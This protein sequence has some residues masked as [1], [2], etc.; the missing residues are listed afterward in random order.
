MKKLKIFIATILFAYVAIINAV[1]NPM[2]YQSYLYDCDAMKY[3]GE[4]YFSG[5][6]LA[7]DMLVS[8]DLRNWGWRTHVF[9]FNNTWHSGTDNDIH[10]SHIR[11]ENGIFHYYA[12]L[13]VSAG[14]R[15][16][17]ATNNISPLAPYIEHIKTGGIAEWIDSDTFK[18]DDG[19][20]YFYSTRLV[21]GESIYSR[22]MSDLFTFSG[23][24]SQRTSPSSGDG[25][26]INEAS[27]VFKYRDKYYMLYNTYGT[28]DFNYRIRGVEAASPTS[29]GNSGKYTE[30]I[31]VRKTLDANREIVRI[32]QPWV[33]EGPNSFER[34]IGYFAHVA[35][36]G[37]ITEQG[38][39]I[40]R[41]YFLGDDLKADAPT[42]RDM[43][44]YHPPPAQPEYLGL[45]NKAS[46]TLPTDWT[47]LAGAWNIVDNELRQTTATSYNNIVLNHKSA[48]NLLAEANVKLIGSGSRRAGLCIVKDGTDWLRVGF[49]QT[50]NRWF[51][52]RMNDGS[53]DTANYA[54]PSGFDFQ[55]YHK[56]QL[57]KNGNTVYIKIDDIPS[58]GLSSVSVNFDGAAKPELFTDNAQAAFDGVIYTIGWDEWNNRVQ[59]WGATKSGVPIVGTWNYVSSG[60]ESTDTNGTKYIFKGDLMNEYEIDV[61]CSVIDNNS[62]NNRGLGIF[63]VAIDGNNYLVAEVDP[64]TTE[65]VV[66]GATNGVPF[67]ETNTTITYNPTPGSWNIRAAKL[68]NKVILFVNGKELKTVN[69]AF[70]ASQVGLITENQNANFSTILVYETK[71]KTLPAPWHSTDLGNVNY[72]GRA[73]FTEDFITINASGNDFANTGDEGHFVYQQIHS[74]KEIIAKVEMCDPADYWSKAALM[75][76]ENLSSNSPMAYIALSRL[77]VNNTNSAQF[78]WRSVTGAGVGFTTKDKYKMFPSYIKLTRMGN[79]FS[80]FWSPD[81]ETWTFVGSTEFPM[82]KICYIG[83]G[84]SAHNSSRFSGA[85][86]SNVKVQDIDPTI[87]YWRFENGAN[88]TIHTADNDDFYLDET[89][90]SNHMST[91]GSGTRPIATNDVPFSVVP[92]TMKQNKLA[93]YFGDSSFMSYLETVGGKM[94]DSYD[95]SNG[96]T[97]EATIKPYNPTWGWQGIISKGGSGIQSDANMPSLYFISTGGTDLQPGG[98]DDSS[99]NFFIS[100]FAMSQYQWYNTAIRFDPNGNIITL[101][102]KELT[103]STYEVE[104]VYSN[105]A[106]NISLPWNEPW[107]IG[108]MFYGG[109]PHSGTGFDGVIDE[110]RISNVPLDTGKFLASQNTFLPFV[111]I[112]NSNIQVDNSVSQYTIGGTNNIKVVGKMN[113]MNEAN[114]SNG[115]FSASA[116]WSVPNIPLDL[117]ANIIS[118][119]GTNTYGDTSSDS[120]TITR[121][122]PEPAFIWIIGLLEL[123][124]ILRKF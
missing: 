87:A 52:E 81:G 7:G 18:D 69:I 85:V 28:A 21:S 108:A 99:N 101:F 61:R 44:G 47:H 102:I 93:L 46:G 84:F 5:N 15:I 16:T 89:V 37:T 107:I 62:N 103:D 42:H 90:N 100:G 19:S 96:W 98:C 29:F 82:N 36:S 53:Y 95:F 123:W 121:A 105:V 67:L 12:H 77:D 32:G 79:I 63:A 49:D 51:Y 1:N 118:V 112:T 124:I 57:Q 76:R 83:L 55:V 73:D 71:D 68:K 17:H 43:S 54:L 88:G 38:Q 34:W 110:V 13:G 10:G 70:A 33:V 25:S 111:N 80:G 6:F 65:L 116:S 11:Y 45:F 113:W 66:S 24:Y 14:N 64:A 50:A 75:I 78:V 20:F 35:T 8:R 120:V 117:G 3:N 92:Q 59:Y 72:A 30:P 2:S 91:T 9:S 4:Y 86:F 104:A 58:P 114:G 41:L 31:V 26:S 119:S 39:Y 109:N 106:D 48:D 74:D 40:D 56:I 94:I 22:T 97:I 27:K 60:I 115:T 23:S 122:L